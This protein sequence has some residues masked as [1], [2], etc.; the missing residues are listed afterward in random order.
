MNGETQGMGAK[1][2]KQP[3]A[4]TLKQFWLTYF[5]AENDF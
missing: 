1:G 4:G 5:T 2:V 3:A